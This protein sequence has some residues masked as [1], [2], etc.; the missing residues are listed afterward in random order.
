MRYG[1]PDIKLNIFGMVEMFCLIRLFV[2]KGVTYCLGVTKKARNISIVA[3]VLICILFI[4]IAI[5]N[6]L[7]R[8]RLLSVLLERILECIKP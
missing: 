7:P 5:S 1:S 6:C 2:E 3:C 4:K 8:E